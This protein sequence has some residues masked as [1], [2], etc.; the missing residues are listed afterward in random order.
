MMDSHI[1][2]S[3]QIRMYVDYVSYSTVVLYSRDRYE[4]IRLLKISHAIK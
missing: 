1:V 2:E 4:I 3:T